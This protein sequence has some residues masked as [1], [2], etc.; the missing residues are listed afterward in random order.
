MMEA[1]EQDD[2]DDLIEE[3]T[4][5]LHQES[6]DNFATTVK[7]I[8]SSRNL[9]GTNSILH[10]RSRGH[11]IFSTN[12]NA[13]E[14]ERPGV[15]DDPAVLSDTP[16]THQHDQTSEHDRG[17]L[18]QTPATTNPVTNEA[19]EDL[20]AN[21][22]ADFEIV[23]GVDPCQVTDLVLFPAI[24]K[25]SLKKR[26]DVADREEYVTFETET[27][28][29][30]NHIA[31]VETD[32]CKRVVLEHFPKSTEL[33]PA[34]LSVDLGDEFDALHNGQVGPV[35]AILVV[36]IVRFQKISEDFLAR[37]WSWTY[38]SWHPRRERVCPTCLDHE[39]GWDHI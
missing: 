38:Q 29:G 19:D 5:T 30:K 17:V 11:G 13:V 20:T 32:R 35:D 3:L 24:G 37:S 21:D 14:E 15:A 39:E 18:N 10:T 22:A 28:A 27:S 12:T 26:L 9:A 4:P 36:Q 6:A 31:E 7:T 34:F 2:E 33:S 25:S 16:S 1:Q 8:F 23:D